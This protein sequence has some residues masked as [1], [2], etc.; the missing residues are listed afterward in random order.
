MQ[1]KTFRVEL[2][3]ENEKEG[4]IIS[5]IQHY[6]WRAP[7]LQTKVLFRQGTFYCIQET[8]ADPHAQHDAKTLG[9]LLDLC[10]NNGVKFQS[11]PPQ[12]SD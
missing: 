2:G 12:R 3:P 7:Q 10:A 6:H 1:F 8:P 4:V 5:W 11:P 9:T